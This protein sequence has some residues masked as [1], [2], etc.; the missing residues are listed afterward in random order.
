MSMMNVARDQARQWA[1]QQAERLE[2]FQSLSPVIWMDIHPRI[3]PYRYDEMFKEYVIFPEFLDFVETLPQADFDQPTALAALTT[4]VGEFAPM[5]NPNVW[6]AIDQT[7]RL[8]NESGRQLQMDELLN[9][10]GTPNALLTRA[11]DVGKA[12]AFFTYEN[13][14]GS[15]KNDLQTVL[16]V[17]PRDVHDKIPNRQQL[18]AAIGRDERQLEAMR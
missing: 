16:R 5:D 14:Q 9:E 17:L 4:K 18:I 3:A 15:S 12:T 1:R 2:N 11:I 7:L 10:D 6:K 13:W 8:L